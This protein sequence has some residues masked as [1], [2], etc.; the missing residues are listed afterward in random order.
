MGQVMTQL[1]LGSGAARS[2]S[3]RKAATKREDTLVMDIKLK[4]I[5]ILQVGSWGSDLGGWGSY[6]G[7]WGSDLGGVN[8]RLGGR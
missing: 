7:G 6:L 5:E 1:T 2:G 3:L 8:D 4:I